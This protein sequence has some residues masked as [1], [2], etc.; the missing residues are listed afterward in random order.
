MSR[1]ATLRLDLME[2]FGMLP[3]QQKPNNTGPT[4]LLV[5]EVDTAAKVAEDSL[6]FYRP[7]PKYVLESTPSPTKSPPNPHRLPP[8]H[9]QSTLP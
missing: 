6:R 4:G 9:I 5:L 3:G 1:D 2:Q 8:K 7:T